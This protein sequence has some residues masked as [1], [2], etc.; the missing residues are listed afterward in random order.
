MD[1]DRRRYVER[2]KGCSFHPGYMVTINLK[3]RNKVNLGIL[4]PCSELGISYLRSQEIFGERGGR[5][6]GPFMS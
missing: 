2:I 1:Q 4:L 6:I 3:L 5:F